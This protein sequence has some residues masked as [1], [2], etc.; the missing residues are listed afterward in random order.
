MRRRQHTP[1]PTHEI[2][3]GGQAAVAPA[4]P[5]WRRRWPRPVTSLRV[6]LTLWYGV[7]LALILLLCSAAIYVTEQQALLAQTDSHLTQRLRYW[8]GADAAG[9]GRG[10]ASGDPDIAR[11]AEVVLLVTPTGR[12]VQTLAAG[13]LSAVKRPWDDAVQALLAVA[14][15]RAP[16]VVEQGLL[17]TTAAGVTKDGLTPVTVTH[18]AL[19]RL[20]GLPLSGQLGAA[21]L[22]VGVRSDVPRQMATLAQ[23]LEAVVPLTLL[24]CAGGGYW[25][26]SRAL[27]PMQAITR[28]AQEIGA[29]D[30]SR[31]LSP[32]RDD[33]VG[34]LATT[35][36]QMLE[37]LEAAFA[38]QRQFTA[39]ASHELRTPLTIVDLEAT[40]A[41]ARPRTPR[42][43]RQAIAVMRQE[44]RHMARLLDDLLLLARADS[45][46]I[47]LPCAEVDLAEVVLDVTERLAP[48]AQRSAMVLMIEALPEALVWGDQ[49]A[50]ARMLTNIIENALKYGAG[51]G[52]WVRLSGGQRQQNAVDGVWLRVADDGPGVAAE[53]LPHLGERFYR[54]DH[55]RTHR[56]DAPEEE[57]PRE[58][59]PTGTG[60]GLAIS[61]GIISDHG[62]TLCLHSE[63][64]QGVVVDLWVPARPRPAG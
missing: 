4:T 1:A 44:M 33:E 56:A 40:R 49:E 54:V 12:V 24:L 29:T 45:A 61:Q 6:R 7:M 59:R 9:S 39:D 18:A 51:W 58:G 2:R 21:L 55:A 35:I 31:R 47:A 57:P 32:R 36:N 10:A 38:R 37:R 34:Q 62:G 5:E 63:S 14:R 16:T 17:L 60:L 48:L 43:Y 42:E 30:L 20:T 11:G 64:G 52:T 8:A 19:F 22:V 28:T 23:T 26:A 25:L 27:R 50:L 15:S 3:P 13:R 53:H 46:D 41:L